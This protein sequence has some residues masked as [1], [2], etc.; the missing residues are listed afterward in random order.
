MIRAT[1]AATLLVAAPAMAQDFSEGS[2]AQSWGLFAEAPATFEARVVDIL[3]ELTGDC[4][5]NCG[6]GTRQLG[7]L[8]SADDVLV[9]PNKNSQ[10]LFTGAVAELQ[11]FCGQMVEVDGLML[12]DPD[13]G[14]ANIYLVQKIRTV[15]SE[16]WTDANRWTEVWGERNPEAAE[17]EGPWFRNDPR[18]Q[19]RI[20]TTGY[21][22]LGLE[23]DAAAIRELYE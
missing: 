9:F 22:G 2:E 5:D 16:D 8:R 13:L 23:E 4:A 3:C 7:L 18:V 21:F 10:P 12:T 17:A 11:P 14:A 15:G 6:D 20:A 1:L 19:A